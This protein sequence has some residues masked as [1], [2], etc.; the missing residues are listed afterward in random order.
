M[1]LEIERKFLIKN[2]SWRKEADNGTLLR[3]GYLNSTAERTVR[4]RINGD[5]AYLTIKGKN[6]NLTRK[7]FEYEIPADEAESLLELCE[8][9]IIEKTRFLI[10]KNNH[11]WE[12]DIFGGEN[13]GLQVAEIELNS[14]E[15]KF[16]KPTC[17][18]DEV[19]HDSRYYNSSLISN[20]YSKWSD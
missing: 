10:K 6:E 17:L 12:I 7:E 16:Q 11:T 18:G 3:Q 2:D 14:E 19:S 20:P 8:K 15:E 4:V 5:E 1:G 9:P 13:K